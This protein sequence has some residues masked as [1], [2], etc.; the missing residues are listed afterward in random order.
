[1]NFLQKPSQTWQKFR[2][3]IKSPSHSRTLGLVGVLAFVGIISLTVIVAQQQQ[4]TKQ[5]ADF[6][7]C[8]NITNIEPCPNDFQPYSSCS[9]K[10]DQCKIGDIVYG[11]RPPQGGGGE[12]N[13]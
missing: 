4:Q 5:R 2:D 12:T 10:I 3:F 8:S 7:V 13:D 11:C 6:A 1:M 9:S